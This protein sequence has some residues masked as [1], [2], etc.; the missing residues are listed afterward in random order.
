MDSAVCD[1]VSGLCTGTKHNRHC[2]VLGSMRLD[3][4]ATPRP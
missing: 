4:P 2:G 1:W 3:Y